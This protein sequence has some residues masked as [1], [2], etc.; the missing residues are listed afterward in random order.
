M[1]GFTPAVFLAFSIHYGTSGI[2]WTPSARILT[3]VEIKKAPGIL[4]DPV[5]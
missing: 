5:L 4:V 2:V 3:A 1:P